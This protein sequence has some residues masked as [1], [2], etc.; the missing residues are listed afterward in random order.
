M[1]QSWLLQE[2]LRPAEQHRKTS[3][4]NAEPYAY[5]LR[6]ILLLV[7]QKSTWI[8]CKEFGRGHNIVPI[9]NPMSILNLV[10]VSVILTVVP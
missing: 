10:L 7:R 8:L 4:I 1:N 3:H 9:Q 5:E 2:P 6:S